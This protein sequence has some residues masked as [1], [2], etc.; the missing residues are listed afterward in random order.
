MV[1]KFLQLKISLL[2]VMKSH[3]C[4]KRLITIDEKKNV[5]C[6]VEMLLITWQQFFVFKKPYIFSN[7]M[8]LNFFLSFLLKSLLTTQ[9]DV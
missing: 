7:F 6:L 5:S 9:N 1:M 3:K 4:I 2:M 8:I